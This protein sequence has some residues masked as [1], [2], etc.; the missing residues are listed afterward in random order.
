ML[1]QPSYDPE[2]NLGPIDYHFHL[3]APKI[4]HRQYCLFLDDGLINIIWLFRGMFFFHRTSQIST[5]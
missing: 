4:R 5:G 3:V 1:N 2:A